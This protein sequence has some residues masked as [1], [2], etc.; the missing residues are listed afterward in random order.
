MAG[1]SAVKSENVLPGLRQEFIHTSEPAVLKI[2]FFLF[3]SPEE[4]FTL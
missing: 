1:P 4:I 3:F 2:L